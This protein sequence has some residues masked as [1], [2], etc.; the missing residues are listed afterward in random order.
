[1]ILFVAA[2]VSGTVF[3]ILPGCVEKGILQAVTPFLL[4]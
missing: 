1:M 2:T 4:S 3:G